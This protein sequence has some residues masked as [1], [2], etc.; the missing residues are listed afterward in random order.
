M[1]FCILFS[2]NF[3]VTG[4]SATSSFVILDVSVGF[5]VGVLFISF[6]SNVKLKRSEPNKNMTG[7]VNLLNSSEFQSLWKREKK[8]LN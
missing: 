3:L 1:R 4:L 5:C 2:E 8:K 6:E 7:K